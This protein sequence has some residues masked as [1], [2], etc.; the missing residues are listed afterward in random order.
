MSRARLVLLTVGALLAFAGNSLLCRVALRGG[1][2]DPASFTA[3][4]I[5]SG[6]SVLWLVQRSRG[7]SV[8]GSGSW[9]SAFALFVY[10]AAFSFAYLSLTAGTGALLLFAAVQATMIFA[11]LRS[12]ER[13]RPLQIVGLLF[14]FGGLVL[15]LLPGLAAPPLAGALLMLSAGVA[16]GVYSLRGRSANDATAATAGNFL[17]A[18]VFALLLSIVCARWMRIAPA[19]AA[20]ALLSGAVT[21]GLGYVIWYAALPRLRAITAASVQLSVPVLTAAAGILFLGEMMT[22]RFLC[23]AGAVLGGIALVVLEKRRATAAEAHPCDG[24]PP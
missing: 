9:R 22:G 10:A 4:R 15:L 18:A 11:G 6:A 8:L 16:W 20:F 17:R 3:L 1:A 24:T 13:L 7:Q 19:G 21:S 12:R 5:V 23:A 14:A 2:M